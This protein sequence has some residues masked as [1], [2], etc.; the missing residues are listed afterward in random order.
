MAPA[1][2]VARGRSVNPKAVEGLDA[3]VLAQA[4]A[5]G[6][7]GE[8]AGVVGLRGGEVGEGGALVGL[9]G[10]EELGGGEA[11]PTRPA[12]RA[13]RGVRWRETGRW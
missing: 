5:G 3:E 10:D 6:G 11:G 4:V 1:A 9:V 8:G 2:A 7:G 13:S 12:A